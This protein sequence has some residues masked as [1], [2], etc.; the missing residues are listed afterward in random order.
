MFTLTLKDVLIKGR[1]AINEGTLQGQYN[2]KHK[3]L[4]AYDGNVGTCAYRS[5]ADGIKYK[6]IVGTAIP[7]E[8]YNENWDKDGRTISWL[9]E[10]KKITFN[11]NESELVSL[12]QLQLYHDDISKNKGW[13]EFIERFESL[14]K[15]YIH[16]S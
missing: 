7:D 6:C 11:G 12:K 16:A 9:L 3:D 13:P 15:E 4:M 14:E 1:E 8:F 5:E 2:Y 10:N